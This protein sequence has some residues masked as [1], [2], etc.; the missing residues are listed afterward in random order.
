M[1]SASR[2]SAGACCIVY[3]LRDGISIAPTVRD[4]TEDLI[5]FAIEPMNPSESRNVEWKAP[6]PSCRES[7]DRELKGML[8]QSATTVVLN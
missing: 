6:N 5:E 2:L 3:K 4:R 1:P 8:N 7:R